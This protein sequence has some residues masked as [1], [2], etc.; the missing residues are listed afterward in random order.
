[1]RGGRGGVIVL[2][3]R[4]TV[5]E[6]RFLQISDLHLGAPFGTLPA[7]RRGERRHEQQRVLEAAIARASEIAAHAILIPGDLFDAEG[8]D[9]E[10]LT[11]ALRVFDVP[12]CPPVFIAPGNH[13]PHVSSSHYWSPRLLAAR[14][15]SWPDHIHVFSSPGWTSQPLAGHAVTLWGRCFTTGAP[16]FD[17]PLEAQALALGEMDPQHVHIGLFHGSR[18]QHCPPGQK[19]T[20]PFSDVEVQAAPF[21]YLAVGHYHV[22]SALIEDG[23]GARLAYAGSPIALG[24][25]ETGAHGALEV[26][27]TVNTDGSRVEITPVPLDP[28][29]IHAVEVDVTGLAS[30]DQIDRRGVTAIDLA[31]I[32]ERDLVIVRLVGRLPRG[33]RYTQPGPDLSARVWA[34][35]L[36]ARAMRPDYDLDEFRGREPTTTED[37]FVRALLDRLDEERD[38]ALRAR[39]ASAIYYGLDA[40]RLRDV[41]P[42][43][44]EI[45][46]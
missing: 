1:M 21:T 10:T 11:F 31:D 26:R 30:A 3:G 20:A 9:A 33:I 17:R 2:G 28:R 12:G 36:D 29:R 41:A 35:R 18:E 39:I 44:E 46:A 24:W 38:P 43:Y 13:D 23:R 37:Q 4:E 40:F 15:S 7:E 6:F 32:D 16:T 27:V 42:A 22:P 25:G 45:E 34:V 14:G 5:S 8:V 19:L